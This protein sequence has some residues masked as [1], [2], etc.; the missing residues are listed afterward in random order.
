MSI[1]ELARRVRW[2]HGGSRTWGLRRMRGSSTG[3]KGR[4]REG[5]LKWRVRVDLEGDVDFLLRVG[6]LFR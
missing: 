1:L 2:L 4:V 5:N 6:K 3:L